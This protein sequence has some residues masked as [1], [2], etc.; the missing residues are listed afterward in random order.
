M[1]VSLSKSRLWVGTLVMQYAKWNTVFGMTTKQLKKKYASAYIG[2][3]QMY[4]FQWDE[5]FIAERDRYVAL[6]IGIGATLLA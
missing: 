2:Y 4:H 5:T 3:M 1:Y 6:Q